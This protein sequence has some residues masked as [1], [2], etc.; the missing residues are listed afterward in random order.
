MTE[1][2]VRGPLAGESQLPQSDPDGFLGLNFD[3]LL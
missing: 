1:S 3:S 2:I